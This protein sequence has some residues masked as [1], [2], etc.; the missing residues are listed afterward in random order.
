MTSSVRG[1][2]P[3]QA[4][5]WTSRPSPFAEL[6]FTDGCA[7]P[8]RAQPRGEGR[9]S[10]EGPC[11]FS[12]FAVSLK[13]HRCWIVRVVLLLGFPLQ[14]PLGFADVGVDII[15]PLTKVHL[16][17]EICGC[18]SVWA[19]HPIHI[20]FPVI[21]FFLLC[22]VNIV[23]LFFFLQF[24]IIFAWWHIIICLLNQQ[25]PSSSLHTRDETEKYF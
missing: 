6:S 7:V 24:R 12:A 18:R 15:H 2:Q 3:K 5:P 4:L 1:Y 23:D 17:Y 11:K 22:H 8:D 10:R 25:A 14:N 20:C 19:I 21:Q 16:V 9:G 13:A